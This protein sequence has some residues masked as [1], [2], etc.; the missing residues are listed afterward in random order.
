MTLTIWRRIGILALL[1][2]LVVVLILTL[3]HRIGVVVEGHGH[4]M[5]RSAQLAQ[6]RDRVGAGSDIHPASPFAVPEGEDPA[7]AVLV[8][9][10]ALSLSPTVQL[11]EMCQ[12]RAQA[13]GVDAG[14]VQIALD[15]RLT[16]REFRVF[17]DELAMRLPA[18]EVSYLEV[19]HSDV[20]GAARPLDVGLVLTLAWT[21]RV[22]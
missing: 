13:S 10:E 4:L 14:D 19:S 17:V 7:A 22:S 3:S 20:G 8:L 21:R 11:G 15:C 1:A 12:A 6:L 18:A 9:V 16:E 5:D 2:G